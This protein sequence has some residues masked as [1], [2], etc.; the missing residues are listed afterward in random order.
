MRRKETGLKQQKEAGGEK[1]VASTYR[2]GPTHARSAFFF[3]FILRHQGGIKSNVVPQTASATV[4]FRI[5]PW[6]STQIVR[7]HVQALMDA[8]PLLAGQVQVTTEEAEA[9]E[10]SPVTDPRHYGVHVLSEAL[11]DTFADDVGAPAWLPDLV[12]APSI[13]VG[14][15]GA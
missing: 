4:N 1:K 11:H 6:E 10:P 9:L 5:A 14:N 2:D 13:M 7:D 15:T 8:D 3:T 12:V